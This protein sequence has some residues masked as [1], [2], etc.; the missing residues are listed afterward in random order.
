M[1]DPFEFDGLILKWTMYL[2]LGLIL[3]AALPGLFYIIGF[4]ATAA[5][6][7]YWELWKIA[8]DYDSGKLVSPFED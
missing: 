4:L 2:I 5:L 8:K 7:V 3:F 6:C 1:T